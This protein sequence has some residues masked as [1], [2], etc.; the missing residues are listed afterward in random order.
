MTDTYIIT[1]GDEDPPYKVHGPF[2]SADHVGAYADWW[3]HSNCDDL[4][5][6]VVELDGPH[7]APRVVV[8]GPEWSA[9]KFP[10]H[11]KLQPW[12]RWEDDE[13]P[14]PGVRAHNFLLTFP[15]EGGFELHGPFRSLA[16]AGAYGSQWEKQQFAEDTDT[17]AN[18]QSLYIEDPHAPP[19]VVTPD[20]KL[21]A[22]SYAGHTA[23]VD[24]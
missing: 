16:A 11:D 5:W 21:F 3:Q 1:W 8:P 19:S 6:E 15:H 7:A 17:A 18:W 4:N 12:Y 23:E 22:I 24:A 14:N 2:E 10:G 9:D 20:P 13:G